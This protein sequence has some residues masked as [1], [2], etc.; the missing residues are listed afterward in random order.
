M[1]FTR[2]F[3]GFAPPRRFDGVPFTEALIREAEA[4]AGP[5]TTIDT[6]AL[7]PVDAD[8][9]APAVRNLTTAEATLEDGWYI[10]RWRDDNAATFDSSPINYA[11][12]AEARF[13]TV[14]DMAVRQGRTFTDS[15]VDTVD[16]L[17]Q[18]ATSTIA[19]VADKDDE[20]A[21]NLDPI[22]TVLRGLTVELVSRAFAN[23]TGL[24]SI[25]E[26]LGSYQY[27]QSFNREA[28]GMTLTDVERRLVRR[29][30]NGLNYEVR[31]P[32]LAEQYLED[33]IDHEGS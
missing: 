26:Q 21:L 31:T 30:V 22:P 2:T 29:V 8:P 33:L 4:Q 11:T 15:E 24:N 16:L 14:G 23:P 6:I 7:S 10:I 9:S 1:A 17:I 27:Q 18:L 20:W 19:A 13:A 3:Q 12:G 28:A 5:Y 32:T 25:M